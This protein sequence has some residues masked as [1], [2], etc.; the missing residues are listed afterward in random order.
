MP[1]VYSGPAGQERRTINRRTFLGTALLAYQAFRALARAQGTSRAPELRIREIRAVRLRDSF[2]SRY[3]LDIEAIR[4]DLR[5]WQRLP[6][7]HFP[8]CVRGMGGPY[9]AAGS[10]VEI[11]FW[12]RPAKRWACLSTA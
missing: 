2:N 5:G 1:D 7:G 9:L 3:P 12:D 11:A 4:L 8:M 6:G 10:G